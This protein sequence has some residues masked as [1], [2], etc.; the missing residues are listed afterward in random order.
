MK[1]TTQ[2]FN[3][4]WILAGIAALTI[5]Q[6]ARATNPHDW[7][8]NGGNYALTWA[9]NNNWGGNPPTLFDGTEDLNF[10][11]PYPRPFAI[12]TLTAGSSFHDLNIGISFV[13]SGNAIT[14]TGNV[15]SNFYGALTMPVINMNVDNGGH[16]TTYTTNTDGGAMNNLLVNGVISGAGGLTKAQITGDSG[17]SYYST[18]YLTNNNSYTG[19][20]TI[21]GGVISISSMAGIGLATTDASNLVFNAA[22]YNNPAV[23]QYT[24]ADAT[25]ARGFTISN[26][27]IG[28]FDITAHNLTITGAAAVSTG[29]LSKRGAGMLTLTGANLY[30]GSTNLDAGTLKLDFSA[31][32]APANQIVSAASDLNFGTGHPPYNLPNFGGSQTLTIQGAN[33]AVTNT[34]NFNNLNQYCPVISQVTAKG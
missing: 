23:L 31:P 21:T 15:A 32:G 1:K 12:N 2:R 34:Q 16:T 19:V 27:T 22:S 17:A 26:G 24:G 6:S 8:G 14:L 20:T 4:A 10:T 28:V 5:A 7:Q 25:T 11:S 18:L 29:S 13:L 9:D 33:G 30:T 3:S